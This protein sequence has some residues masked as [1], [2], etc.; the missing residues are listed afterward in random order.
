MVSSDWRKM[1]PC[2]CSYGICVQI[3]MGLQ[4]I[5]ANYTYVKMKGSPH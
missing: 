5:I 2:V 3:P 1:S 4:Y